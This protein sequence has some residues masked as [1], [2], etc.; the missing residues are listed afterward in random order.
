MPSPPISPAPSPAGE[1]SAAVPQGTA[2]P[3]AEPEL[4]DA[5]FAHMA[6]F[7][8]I[9]ERH[10]G[11]RADGSP[12]FEASLTYAEAVLTAAGFDVERHTGEA[13]VDWSGD[14][15]LTRANGPEFDGADVLPMRGSP[16]TDGTLTAGLSTSSNKKGCQLGD[17]AESAGTVVLVERG[18]CAFSTKSALAK[19]AGAVGLI[20]Y[21]P[22]GPL[23]GDLGT[24][25]DVVPTVSVS[26][27]GAQSLI[28]AM[29]EGDVQVRFTVSGESTYRAITNLIAHRPGNHSPAVLLGAHLD[30][31]AQ[32]PGI[33]DN[34]SGVSL[35]LATAERLA[36]SGEADNLRIALWGGEELGL[37]GSGVYVMG[38]GA[39]KPDVSAYVNLDMVASPNGVVGIHGSGTALDLTQ[40]VLREAGAEFELVQMAGYSDHAWF[41]SRQIPTVG[42][43]TGA[44]DEVT[45]EQAATFGSEAGEPKDSC[46]HRACDTLET[47]DTPEVRAR[48]QV[49]GDAL[50]AVIP[51]LS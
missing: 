16:T 11:N 32:G 30:G 44:G 22:A 49:I 28:R 50:L 21:D 36:R 29:A 4:V 6:E 39:T 19:E 20:I 34:A 2:S 35:A 37:L 38:F 5:S 10:A 3:T 26:S 48:M 1:S 9:A 12:G 27:D 45:Q 8:R 40:R 46:Y 15:T 13:L 51:Q 24:D 43:H 18:E 14:A 25:R 23:N 42:F 31:V 7:Q 41:E 33:N 17:Y 47:V